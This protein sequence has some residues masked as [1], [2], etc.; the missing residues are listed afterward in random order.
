MT[1]LKLSDVKS[2]HAMM[3][4]L[5]AMPN[6]THLKVDTV[7]INCDGY[8]WE[9]IINDYLPK[10]QVF[11]FKMHIELPGKKNSEEHL[12]SLVDSFRTPFWLVKHQWFIR[13]HHSP[14]EYRM[15]IVLYTVPYAFGN[16]KM[17]L[18]TNTYK[19]T[20]PGDNDTGI[21]AN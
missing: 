1:I 16:G 5:Q 11:R 7:C 3:N 6:L 14:G 18:P 9:R 21:V 10:L 19:T 8:R 17:C 12:N 13:C 20:Y 15:V 2:S 4:I